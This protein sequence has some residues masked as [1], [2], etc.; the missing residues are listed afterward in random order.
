MSEA[1]QRLHWMIAWRHLRVGDKPPAFVGPLLI[2]AFYLIIIGLG[3]AARANLGPE[4]VPPPELLVPEL[5]IGAPKPPPAVE[6]YYGLIGGVTLFTGAMLL[7]GA[8]LARFFTVLATVIIISVMLGCMALV[9]VL[10]LM[11]GLEHELRDKILGQLAH[12]RIAREDHRPFADYQEVTERVAA[13]PGIVGASPYLQGEVMVRNGLNRQGGILTGIIPE[14][15]ASVSYLPDIIVK[16]EGSYS[17]L[18]HP[19]LIPEPSFSFEVTA[20]DKPSVK[21]APAEEER[22]GDVV[23]GPGAA[24][25]APKLELPP[26]VFGSTGEAGGEGDEGDD[27]GWEDPSLEIPK[28]REAGTIP[29]ARPAEGASKIDAAPAPAPDEGDD[30]GWE[31]PALLLPRA[32]VGAKGAAPPQARVVDRFGALPRPGSDED[33]GWEDPADEIPKLREAG[34]LPP[35]P[36]ATDG[37]EGESEGA[38]AVADATPPSAT[39]STTDADEHEDDGAGSLPGPVLIGSE[40]AKELIAHVGDRVQL[41]SPIGRQTPA[42]RIPGRMDVRVAGVFDADHYEYDRWL[43]YAPLGLV[44][45]FLRTG[46]R[47]SGIEVRVDNLEEVRARKEALQ[48]LITELGRDDLVVQDWQELN[49]SL[50][51]A[52]ALEKIAVFIALLC[53]ILVASFGILGSNLMSVLEKSKEIAIL[54]TMGT[55]DSLIQRVFIAEG[56]CMGI[57][58]G[59]LGIV[60]GIVLCVVLDRFGFPLSGDLAGFDTLPVA[61][62]PL[63]VGLVGVSALIIVW[64]SSLY[65]ARVA[66]RMRPVEALRKAEA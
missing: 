36:D 53:V 23:P 17:Y 28:L 21:E 20:D 4:V 2:I 54:K 49:A 43:V 29:P 8:L 52:M 39:T 32:P 57:V 47:V 66:S 15:Q 59:I 16:N 35:R 37:G 62:D 7:L 38:E 19:E 10:S 27:E 13:T 34:V 1:R 3:F 64:L 42:G 63:E 9:V 50:F 51:S 44:Q 61:I 45:S 30:D 40:K 56:L 41:I 26:T 5:A 58:G 14:R 48:R 31:D 18:D 65:P 6:T 55:S 25:L 24:A 46:D 11:T 60:T 22:L 12:I 33:E